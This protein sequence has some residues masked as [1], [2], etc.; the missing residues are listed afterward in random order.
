[1]GAVDTLQSCPPVRV[2]PSPTGTPCQASQPAC[3]HLGALQ[4]VAPQAHAAG[5]HNRQKG[6]VWRQ[7][8][9]IGIPAG[10]HMWTGGPDF[11]QVQ[12]DGSS[13]TKGVS[14]LFS[15]QSHKQL[16]SSHQQITLTDQ[17]HTGESCCAAS[18]KTHHRPSTITW[19]LRVAGLYTRTRPVAPPC[20]E[21]HSIASA[22]LRMRT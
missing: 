10:R 15:S 9:S 13:D 11:G 18:G 17:E 14:E 20:T 7:R 19:A 8:H 4:P 22:G 6:S 5:F 3:A 16:C 1:V 12:L 2:G 21:P